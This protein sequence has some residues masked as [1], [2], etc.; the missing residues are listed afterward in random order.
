MDNEIT[1]LADIKKPSECGIGKILHRDTEIIENN[2]R[3]CEVIW[4]L[5]SLTNEGLIQA[6]V[7][8]CRERWGSE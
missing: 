1:E 8:K 2:I 4:M 7:D 6:S 3:E 5:K